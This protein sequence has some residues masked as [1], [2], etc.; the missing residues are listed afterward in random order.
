M[1]HRNDN[2][3]E[4]TTE[5]ATNP[6]NSVNTPQVPTQEERAGD[7]DLQTRGGYNNGS[8]K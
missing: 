6:M 5:N 3:N 4:S 7:G 1:F 2:G 8:G